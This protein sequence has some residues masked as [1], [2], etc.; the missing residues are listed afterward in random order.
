MK[1]SIIEDTTLG[2]SAFIY[3]SLF[4]LFPKLFEIQVISHMLRKQA[5]YALGPASS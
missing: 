5:Q 4:G 3:M 2:I 1:K